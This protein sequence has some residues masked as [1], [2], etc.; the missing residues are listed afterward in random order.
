MRWSSAQRTSGYRSRSRRTTSSARVWAPRGRAMGRG[1][2]RPMSTPT[3]VAVP[4]SG[5]A[6][7][8]KRRTGSTTRSQRAP[9]TRARRRGVARLRPTRSGLPRA[10]WSTTSRSRT[11]RAATRS[12]RN[13]GQSAS[14]SRP[15]PRRVAIVGA[16]HRRSASRT[17]AAHG[18]GHVVLWVFARDRRRRRCSAPSGSASDPRPVRDARP[19]A[20]SPRPHRMAGRASRCATS[21]PA[22][23]RRRGS[24]ST[25]ARSRTTPIKATGSR[26]RSR[27]RMAEP[28]FDPALFLLAFDDDGLAGFNWCKVHDARRRDDPALGEIFVIGV[29]PR[30]RRARARAARSRS[31]GC[32]ALAARGVTTGMLFTAADNTRRAEAVPR[33]SGSPCTASTAPTSATSTG[34]M[35]RAPLRRDARAS[36]TS[37]RSKLVAQPRYRAD[38]GVRRAVDATRVRSRRSP[39]SP[40]ALR[41]D[42][43]DRSAARARRRA[44]SS[45]GDDGMTVKWLWQRRRRRAGRD[46]ADALPRPR[47][48]LRLVAGRAA[49]WA[50]RSARP[51]RPA[52]NA[53]STSARSSNRSSARSTTSPQRVGNVVFMGMGEPLANVDARA[54]GARRA[55]TTTSGFSARHLTVSTVGVVPGM[56]RLA[57]V[58]A[59]RHARRLAARARRRAPRPSSCRSTAATRSPTSS[60]RPATYA[61]REGPPGHLR[62]RVHRR[63]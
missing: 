61:R 18:G 3:V 37:C 17:S 11:W 21:S 45:S 34:L 47:D 24:P 62:V 20:R 28:W 13:T 41:N 6:D 49:R 8:S 9:V 36:S 59:A 39:T 12:R 52:S 57:R 53:T 16:L 4:P 58:P 63:A 43:A 10:C 23:T 42:L 48:G 40:N 29:D 27:R 30:T 38:A 44:P 32:D 19:A 7:L 60:T 31:K 2:P 35:H 55:C 1:Y 25:T 5:F 50:A 26:R 33:H 14:P 22:A 15:T 56:R 51:A 46:G 54:R